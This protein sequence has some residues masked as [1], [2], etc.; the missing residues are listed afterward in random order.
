MWIPGEDDGVW[1]RTTQQDRFER[2]YFPKYYRDYLAHLARELALLKSTGFLNKSDFIE[3]ASKTDSVDVY[4]IVPEPKTYIPRNLPKEKCSEN[5]G[6]R[7]SLRSNG[8][9]AVLIISNPLN[10]AVSA[11]LDFSKISNSLIQN[12][13]GVR[14]LFENAMDVNSKTYKTNRNAAINLETATVEKGYYLPFQNKQLLLDFGP[15]DVHVLKFVIDSNDQNFTKKFF[16][17][18]PNPANEY[19]V[20]SSLLDLDILYGVEIYNSIGQKIFEQSGGF[21]TNEKGEI[22]LATSTLASGTYY[23]QINGNAFVEVLPLIIK[24]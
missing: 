7:Y 22:Q 19:V 13:V 1:N 8:K 3:I 5:Y 15:M 17:L 2:Q 4:G 14:V 16:Q 11:N 6:L 9:E 24:R 12:S 10:T 21:A 18:Y 20:I 23:V